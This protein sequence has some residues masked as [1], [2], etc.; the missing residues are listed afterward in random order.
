MRSGWS[1]SPTHRSTRRSR[2]WSVDPGTPARSH[3]HGGAVEQDAPIGTA[4]GEASV[5]EQVELPATLVHEVVMLRTQ[6]HEVVEVGRSAVLDPFDDVMHVAVPEP[7]RA[8]RE[9]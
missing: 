1:I 4:H 2:R 5:G 9:P 3:I 6:G 8:V 7:H